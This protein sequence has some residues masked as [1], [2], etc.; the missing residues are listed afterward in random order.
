[1]KPSTIHSLTGL[2]LLVVLALLLFSVYSV[3]RVRGLFTDVSMIRTWLPEAYVMQGSPVFMRQFRVGTV[4]EVNSH[5]FRRSEDG[6]AMSEWFEVLIAVESPWDQELSDLFHISVEVGL[7]GNLTETRLVVLL[8]YEEMVGPFL[9]TEE[10]RRLKDMPEGQ[11]LELSF[12]P[13][14]NFVGTAEDQLKR[15]VNNTIPKV[16]RLLDRSG[17]LAQNLADPSG[18]LMKTLNNLE[19]LSSLLVTELE[20]PESDFRNLLSHLRGLSGS[21]NGM[22]DSI[23]SGQGLVGA[24]IHEA[25]LKER[26]E[27]I[28]SRADSTVEQTDQLLQNATQV[29]AEVARASLVLPDLTDRLRSIMAR[30]DI[31]SRSLPG[32]AED[33]RRTIGEALKVLHAIERLPLIRGNL[34]QPASVPPL[35]LPAMTSP[36]GGAR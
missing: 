1:M 25:A 28:L 22:L 12:Q 20:H 24:L 9:P 13:K 26:L 27:Q 17:D 18:D 29:A 6:H 23:N 32:A 8:P 35:T 10:P 19:R 11:L 3:P 33:V 2:F 21:L 16:D 36:P 34:E 15:L 14:L 5:P 7:L 31:A 30:F 4:H